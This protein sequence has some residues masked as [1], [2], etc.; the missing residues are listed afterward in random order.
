MCIRDRKGASGT[1]SSSGLDTDHGFDS[2]AINRPENRPELAYAQVLRRISVGGPGA[3]L[4]LAGARTRTAVELALFAGR[5]IWRALPA[6]PTPDQPW[7]PLIEGTELDC[8]GR[9]LK[10]TAGSHTH[11]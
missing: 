10:A 4:P 8:G 1:P 7:K 5:W 2:L 11:F 6:T 9:M 3:D